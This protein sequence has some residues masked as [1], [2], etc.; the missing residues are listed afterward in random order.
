MDAVVNTGMKILVSIPYF[1]FL[2]VLL[3]LG[4][5]LF[6][7]TTKYTI[8]AELTTKDNAAFGTLL[9]LFFVGLAIA[10]GGIMFGAT[11]D[12]VVADLVSF[13]VYGVLTLILMRLSVII[14][15]R[16]ILSK[17][18]V[19]KEIVEDKNV[20]TAFVVG[21]SCVATGFMINGA[22]SGQSVD[23]AH[24][25]ADLGVYFIVGQLL[26]VLGGYVFQKI[27]SYDI[28]GVIEHDNNAAAGLSFGG[29]LVAIGIITKTALTGATGD[30]LSEVPTAV[31]LAVCGLAL[32]ILVRTIAD[33]VL[34]PSAQLCKEVSVDKNTA[35]GAIAAAAF[36]AVALSFSFAVGT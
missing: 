10:L 25:I 12:D 24:G 6:D 15:D 1:G 16:F 4:K 30:L 36:V 8:D 13:G 26:L 33:K 14:N 23:L 32:L 20:G 28:H 19:H 3:F 22:L 17:F 29:F 21:G 18:C 35:A 11:Y 27:T 5:L 7:K 31:I 9:A 2:V 34:L